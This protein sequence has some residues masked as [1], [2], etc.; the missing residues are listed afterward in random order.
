M[1]RPV[2]L[3]HLTAI[4]LSPPELVRMAARTGYDRVGLRLIRVSP[5][6][7]GYPVMDDPALLRATRAALDDTGVRVNDIEFVRIEPGF[8]AAA[9]GRFL[10]AGAALGAGH[11][12][13][14]PYDPEPDRL[15]GSLARLAEAARARG[16]GTVLEF[17]PWTVVPD[18]ATAR[19][20]VAASG[21]EGL[22]IL[23]DALHFDRSGSR[24]DDLAATPPALLPFVHLCD[25]P[26][27]PP[28]TTEALLHAGRAE[29]LPPGEGGIDLPAFLARLPAG[30]PLALEV[31]MTARMAAEGAEAVARAAMA[32]LRRLLARSG[33]AAG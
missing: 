24:L 26:R 2:S 6:S 22:G 12:I 16:L 13:A 32:G 21:A 30:I 33:A 1:S 27:R 5:E 29:R 19:R 9:L 11:V 28:Y 8:D 3:A 25:A 15:A 17:F 7:P 31:P 20:V 14:A 10:D 18:L 23:V 4:P